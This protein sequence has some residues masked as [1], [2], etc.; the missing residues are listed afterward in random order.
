M[1]VGER[2][3][4][5]KEVD[6]NEIHPLTAVVP[7]EV[8]TAILRGWLDAKEFQAWC[9]SSFAGSCEAETVIAF[10]V[11]R[12]VLVGRWEGMGLDR[13]YVQ[14]WRDGR[15][16]GRRGKAEDDPDFWEHV[17]YLVP[18]GWVS[19]EDHANGRVWKPAALMIERLRERFADGKKMA[20]LPRYWLRSRSRELRSH[21]GIKR[22]LVGLGATGS[23]L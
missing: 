17:E 10:M 18:N 20:D 1:A 6:I 4:I 12:S 11:Y 22:Y 7:R 8:E 19:E 23:S 5:G 3:E 14:E 2:E 15:A 13:F 21:E 9:L 16:S